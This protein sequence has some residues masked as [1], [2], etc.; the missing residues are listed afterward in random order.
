[1]FEAG[2][3]TPP[4]GRVLLVQRRLTHYRAPFFERLRTALAQRGMSLTL[5]LGRADAAE[6]QRDDAADLPW[7]TTVPT[8]QWA[9]G[10]AVWQ[11]LGPLSSQADLVVLPQENR[12]LSNAPLLL[13]PHRLRV[14]LWGHG[15]DL[16]ADTGWKAQCAQAW[17]AQLTRRADWW[18]AYTAK[19]AAVFGAIGCPP[20]RITTVNNAVDTTALAAGVAELRRADLSGLRQSLGLTMEPVLLFLGSLTAGRRLDLVLAT[21]QLVRA[22]C[23]GLQ[24]VIAGT[25]PAAAQVQAWA[26]GVPGVHCVGAVHGLRKQQWLACA[27][28]LLMPTQLGLGLLDA[29]ASGVPLVTTTAA[30]HGPEIAY[31]QSGHNGLAVAP[32]AE[33]LAQ[34][35]LTVLQQPA[36]AARLREGGL[37]TAATH[38][39]DAMVQRFADGLQAWRDAPRRGATGG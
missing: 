27:D 18:L 30:G 19:S 1:M 36:L 2:G 14:A 10:R 17:K 20:Q 9:Q 29:M 34:A 21:A 13:R 23:P 16:Q 15:R 11:S 25:G 32:D 8:R 37:R 22:T 38:T 31:L 7:A 26:Q 24:L 5:A 33:T 28:A 4:G 39:L 3:F 6:A 35:T 12:L